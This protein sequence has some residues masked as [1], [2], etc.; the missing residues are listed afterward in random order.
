MELKSAPFFGA[1]QFTNAAAVIIG[2]FSN[3]DESVDNDEKR[4]VRSGSRTSSTAG[5]TSV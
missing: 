4:R 3:L 5:K 1:N 2:T